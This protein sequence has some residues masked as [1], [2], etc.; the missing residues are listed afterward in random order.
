MNANM[1]SNNDWTTENFTLRLF[2]NGEY[3]NNNGEALTNGYGLKELAREMIDN[4]LYYL[5]ASSWQQTFTVEDLYVNERLNIACKACNNDI[6]KTSWTGMVGLM[7]PSD[8]YMTYGKSVNDECYNTP[9]DSNYC[10]ITNASYGWIY[11][12]NTA[13]GSTT[14][15]TAWFLSPDTLGMNM[16]TA[17][18]NGNLENGD[19]YYSTNYG[20]RPVVYLKSSVK[21]IDGTGES[22]N[23][24]VLR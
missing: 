1:T 19:V 8:E 24:Y 7:L 20:V 13:Q 15:E 12:S 17:S 4:A 9:A 14:V 16:Y 21:I 6:Q 18:A 22:G 23:P 10:T 11:N 5:G 2:L 3:Y